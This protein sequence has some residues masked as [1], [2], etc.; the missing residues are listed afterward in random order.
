IAASA[1]RGEIVFAGNVAWPDSTAS[2][3]GFPSP[4]ARITIETMTKRAKTSTRTRRGSFV[5]EFVL[6]FP[7]LILAVLAVIEFGLMF[8]GFK[9]VSASS[10]TGAKLAAEQATLDASAVAAIKT[11]IDRQ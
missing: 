4:W 11:E 6:V 2:R 7:L 3:P 8:G 1:R 5:L 9:Q 10:R